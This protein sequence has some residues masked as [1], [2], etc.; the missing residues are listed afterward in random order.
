MK[1]IDIS[2][3]HMHLECVKIVIQKEETR[4][5]KIYGNCLIFCINLSSIWILTF[6]NCNAVRYFILLK[7]S[8][9]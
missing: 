8:A 1:A 2:N 6:A 9:H 4:L 3:I 5:S 7:C